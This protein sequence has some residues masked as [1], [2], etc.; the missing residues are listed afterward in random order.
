MILK[1]SWICRERQLRVQFIGDNSDARFGVSRL[2]EERAP[3][4]LRVIIEVPGL[5]NGS[6]EKILLHPQVDG[7]RIVEGKLELEETETDEKYERIKQRVFADKFKIP[8]RIP[9]DMIAKVEKKTVRNGLCIVDFSQEEIKLPSNKEERKNIQLTRVP[10]SQKQ[11]E[12]LKPTTPTL[13]QDPK[14]QD[15]KTQE[16]QKSQ[17][18]KTQDQKYPGQSTSTPISTPKPTTTPPAN[19][20]SLCWIL[21]GVFALFLAFIVA[22]AVAKPPK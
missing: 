18:Q 15:Q 4:H 3:D 6:E 5:P 2:G 12:I 22:A 1:G 8:I 19:D 21:L 20:S 14:P 13:T 17:D 10:P 7:I 9:R 16:N 11:K